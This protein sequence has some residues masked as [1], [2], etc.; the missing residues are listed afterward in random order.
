MERHTTFMDWKIQ[1]RKDVNSSTLIH[2][3]STDPIKTPARCFVDVDKF[4]L[5]FIHK[6]PRVVQNNI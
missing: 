2:K 5:K 4:I 1:H 6:E 3:F